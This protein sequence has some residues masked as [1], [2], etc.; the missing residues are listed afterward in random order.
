MIIASLVTNMSKDHCKPVRNRFRIII[1]HIINICRRIIESCI[2]NI[3][4]AM[5]QSCQKTI[6][7]LKTLSQAYEMTTKSFVINNTLQFLR[8]S[9]HK[10]INIP[11]QVLVQMYQWTI[12]IVVTNIR[13]NC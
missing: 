1:S 6:V 11:L 4:K 10:H 3:L 5:S 13:K 7:I 2:T 9:C 12:K 8:N